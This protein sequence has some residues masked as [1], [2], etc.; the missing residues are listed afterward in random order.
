MKLNARKNLKLKKRYPFVEIFEEALTLEPFRP[1]SLSDPNRERLSDLTIRV[2]KADGNLLYRQANNIGLGDAKFAL[3]MKDGRVGRR[4]EYLFAIDANDQIIN[5]V[6]WPRNKNEGRGKHPIY[7]FY[8]LWEKRDGDTLSNPLWDKIEYL[9]WVSVEVW[10]DHS[11][12]EEDPWGE[13]HSRSMTVTI[14]GKPDCGF[15]KLQEKANAYE[16]LYLSDQVLMRGA[17]TNNFDII[18]ISGRLDELCT[19]FQDEVY[20]DGMKTVLDKGKVRG[21]SGTFGSVKVLAAEMC[22]YDRVMLEDATSWISFQLQPKSKSMYVLGCG[23]TLPQ[24]RRMIREVVSFWRNPENRT[25]FM[26][27]EEVSVS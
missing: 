26:S 25:E 17:V 14:Y 4:G 12:D 8:A 10:H 2:Q 20:F 1:F 24:I 3:R 16:H 19:Q 5:Q 7:G 23:G 27:D 22:G 15:Q 13:F 18:A 6:R 21:A 9:V 11:G